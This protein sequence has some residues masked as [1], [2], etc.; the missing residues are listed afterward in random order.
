VAGKTDES[1]VT[2]TAVRPGACSYALK[3]LVAGKPLAEV[4]GALLSVRW[5]ATFFKWPK[6]VDPR[7]EL[8]SYRKLAEGPTAVSDQVDQLVFKYG[9]RGPSELDISKKITAAGLGV[10]HFG[11]VA[12]TRLPLTKG[13]WEFSTLSD[14]GVR[15]SVDGKPVIE[16]W[17]WHGPTRDTG[18][19]TLDAGK[20]VEIVVE[21][22][23][24]DGFAVLEFSL[25][26]EAE[27]AK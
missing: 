22:F 20:T 9:M 2:I 16:N 25:S 5:Q 12:R 24:I 4:K 19:L 3:V 13:T 7:K 8:E 17:A 18:K 27:Q 21:H 26:R 11:M 1:Q 10:D 6:D 23:Q 14:D 15:V